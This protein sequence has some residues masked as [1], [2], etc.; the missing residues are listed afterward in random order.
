MLV[1]HVSEVFQ[2]EW[3][4]QSPYPEPLQPVPKERPHRSV[5]VVGADAAWQLAE[6]VVAEADREGEGAGEPLQFPKPG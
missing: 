5:L 4:I 1:N 3:N 6:G 2:N